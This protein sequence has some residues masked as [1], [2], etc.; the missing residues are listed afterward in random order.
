MEN[1]PESMTPDDAP[2]APEEPRAQRV[3]FRGVPWAWKD[4]L[5][6]LTPLVA[7][8]VV[9]PWVDVATWS[10]AA[11]WLV[12]LVLAPGMFGWMVGYPLWVARR[13]RARLPRLSIRTVV[14]EGLLALPALLVFWVVL[15]AVLLVWVGLAHGPPPHNPL[16]GTAR[17]GNWAVIVVFTLVAATVAPITEEVFFRGMVYNGLRQR[18][19]PLWAAILQGVAFGLLHTYGYVHA[20]MVALLGFGLAVLYEWRRTLL[21]PIFVHALQNTAVGA[22]AILAAVQ[23]AHAPVLGINGDP[24]ERG[25]VIT[26][27]FP[28]S[29]A[30]E[31]GLRAG[32]VITAVAGRP[33]ADIR[34]VA[35]VI[36]RKRVGD[37]VWVEFLRAGEDHRVG[38][39]LK[40][41]GR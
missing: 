1:V 14:V 21:A 28:G 22:L 35:E 13:R 15:V 20:A 10:D 2:P 40:G 27:V 11:H 16:E 23:A 24:H 37:R 7:V 9:T 25:C 33:V 41:R 34:T 12:L 29:A 31:A 38:V 32:D 17:A 6:G 4:L 26:Q 19:H 5:I 8:R 18:L 36:R 3:A 30:D 39:V